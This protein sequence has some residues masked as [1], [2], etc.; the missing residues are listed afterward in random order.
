MPLYTAPSPPPLPL[1]A[2]Q[3]YAWLPPNEEDMYEA[4]LAHFTEDDYTLPG[5]DEENGRLMEEEKF[6]L[7]SV[8]Y[9]NRAF[10][11]SRCG[12]LAF[13]QVWGSHTFVLIYVLVVQCVAQSRECL[14]R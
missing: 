6:W 12:A 13:V 11:R 2:T 8:A 9:L 10:E 7:V 4:V 14:L 3:P 1:D 5:A